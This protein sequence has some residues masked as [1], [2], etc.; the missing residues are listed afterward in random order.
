MCRSWKGTSVLI[1]NAQFHCRPIPY[2][3]FVESYIKAYYL[4]E[5]QLETWIRDHKVSPKAWGACENW[6]DQ[7]ALFKWQMLIL[8]FFF[9]YLIVFPDHQLLNLISFQDYS[10][11]QLYSLVSCVPQLNKK[12]RQ[13]MINMIEEAEKNKRWKLPLA[14]FSIDSNSFYAMQGQFNVTQPPRKNMY[15]LLCYVYNNPNHPALRYV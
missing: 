3:E 9:Y 2:R 13:R 14:Y 4:P 8:P 15:L 11:R 10:S 6:E 12:S 5:A 1:V 7:L